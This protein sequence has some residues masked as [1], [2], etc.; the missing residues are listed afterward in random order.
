MQKIKRGN[1]SVLGNTAETF[2]RAS[3]VPYACGGKKREAGDRVG[4]GRVGGHALS[5]T[6][7]FDPFVS[8]IFYF[9]GW[10]GK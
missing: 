1:L 2:K 4:G 6:R 5:H 10:T 7:Q 8:R 9:P 3:A